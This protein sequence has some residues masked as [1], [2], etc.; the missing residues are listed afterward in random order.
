MT[1]RRSIRARTHR[2]S[3]Q[4]G[5]GALPNVWPRS[6]SDTEDGVR[7]VSSD[8]G[9]SVVDVPEGRHRIDVFQGGYARFSREIEI[10]RGDT[11]PLNVSLVR[12]T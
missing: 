1:R 8:D 3:P 4:V 12:P 2:H 9:R 6:A 5:W 7:W 11:V 10:R